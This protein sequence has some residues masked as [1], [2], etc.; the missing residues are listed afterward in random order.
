MDDQ[1]PNKSTTQ[2]TNQLTY[3]PTKQWT[4]Q[5]PTHSAVK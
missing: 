5:Q 1:A 4:N 2:P 3:Q